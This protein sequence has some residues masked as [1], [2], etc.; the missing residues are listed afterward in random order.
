M[1]NSLPQRPAENPHPSREEGEHLLAC[2]N[3]ALAYSRFE[4]AAAA[5]CSELQ[6]VF[7][8][9]LVAL[10]LL[11]GRSVRP[12][13]WSGVADAQ[14]ALA[15]GRK[16]GAAMDE[17]VDQRCSLRYPAAAGDPPR[18]TL[19]HAELASADLG[20]AIL[21]VPL[22]ARLE[23]VGCVILLRGEKQ[24]WSDAERSMAE[25]IAG[26]L[27]PVLL[28]RQQAD[29]PLRRRLLRQPGELLEK[30]QGPRSLRL[31]LGLLGVA[32]CLLA[33]GLIPVA[34]TVRAE[35]RLQ[36]EIERSIT[37]PADSFIQDVLVRPG[38]S[39][40]EGEL[41]LTLA[42]QD[43]KS[44]QRRLESEH[45]RHRSELAEAFARQ[46]RARMVASQAKVEEVGSQLDLITDQLAR[47]RL[48][49][50]FPGVVIRG[51]LQQQAGAPVKRGDVLLVISPL[52][53]WRL[54]LQVDER[55]IAR[56]AAGQ[57]GEVSFV[58]LPGERFALRVSRITPVAR[59]VDGRNGFEVEATLE[60]RS[61]AVRP[62]LEGVA[63]LHMGRRPLL[64]IWGSRLADWLSLRLWSVF[65]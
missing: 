5:V 32:G 4:E 46:D 29:E 3:A 44:E 39:V 20:A 31:W 41:L 64:A 11:R 48:T 34:D 45:A 50:P 21:S 63:Q 57:R 7:G 42:D 19:M 55:D 61:Q 28:L 43:L 49:A 23:A 9:E 47:T 2:L 22:P 52:S 15:L 54:I 53:A 27:G 38:S 24:P 26:L 25:E 60:G 33:G 1:T 17:C 30:L 18:I 65:G 51:D 13:G 14:A 16:I 6:A 36:G 37:A 35:A 10:G 62:G 59:V 58:A 8:C 12:L 56:L 40:A